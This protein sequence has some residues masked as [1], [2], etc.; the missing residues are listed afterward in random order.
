MNEFDIK[1]K[2][3]DKNPMH[4]DRSIAISAEIL[5]QIP[6]KPYFRALEYGAGT[7]ILSFLLKDHLQEIILMDN[8]WQ[9][10]KMIEEKIA[11]TGVTNMKTKFF[12]L[13]HSDYKDGKFDIIYT[14]MVLHHVTDIE[15]IITKFHNL[16]NPGGFLAIADLYTED[17]S[18]HGEGFI[19]HLGFDIENLSKIETER[20]F[21]NISHKECFV[22]KRKI[23]ET[24]TK[25]F[26]VFLLIAKA[27]S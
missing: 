11:D 25:Q 17:G 22:V 3:W 14:Q 4:W 13:E 2:D 21:D 6:L 1:A 19:G 7:G 8:S 20:G 18:F 12:D 26:P 16:L 5:K 10:I 23:S 24:E 9:M 15:N 27:N